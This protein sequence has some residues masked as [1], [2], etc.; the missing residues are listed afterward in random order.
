MK[1]M[2]KK[3]DRELKGD[4]FMVNQRINR[5]NFSKQSDFF[6]FFFSVSLLY[7]YKLID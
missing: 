1:M 2:T 7:S 5:A 4:I 3:I 6:F